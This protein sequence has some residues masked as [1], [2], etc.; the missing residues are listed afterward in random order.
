MTGG[1]VHGG[2]EV[3]RNDKQRELVCEVGL[4]FAGNSSVIALPILDQ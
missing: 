4:L 1:T 2:V 3:L